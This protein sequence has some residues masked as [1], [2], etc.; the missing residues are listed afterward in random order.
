MRTLAIK[1]LLLG[2]LGSLAACGND[3]STVNPVQVASD[4][5]KGLFSN[6]SAPPAPIGDQ[7]IA[8]VL[9]ATQEPVILVNLADLETE[10]LLL[11]IETNGAYQTFATSAR[12]TITQRDGMI[13]ATR[14]LGGD[15]MSSEPEALLAQVRSGRPGQVPYVV[16]YLRGDEATM[17]YTYRCT[18]TPAGSESVMRGALNLDGR[19][20][21]ADCLGDGTPFTASFVTDRSGAIVKSEQWLGDYIGKVI[22]QTLRK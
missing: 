19:K 13:T 8:S 14:G 2:A 5:G 3:T 6:R 4:V 1:A 15:L 17:T 22:S 10:A 11:R 18:V 12:Q 9:A 20:V 16:R 21:T 7:Q